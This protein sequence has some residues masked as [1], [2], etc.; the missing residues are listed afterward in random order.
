MA[1]LQALFNKRVP[2]PAFNQ[3]QILIPEV[4][5]PPP[6]WHPATVPNALTFH[7]M[8]ASG[9]LP[10]IIIPGPKHRAMALSTG[11]LNTTG[12]L[13]YSVDLGVS[14]QKSDVPLPPAANIQGG[15]VCYDSVTREGEF[16]A[17]VGDQTIY[18][19]VNGT[20]WD[21]VY[22][23]EVPEDGGSEE[24][25]F[26]TALNGVQV[27]LSRM[28]DPDSYRVYS[29]VYT[30]Y[31]DP[32][33]QYRGTVMPGDDQ[34]YGQVSAF[35][36][37]DD[38]IWLI[39]TTGYYKRGTVDSS[40][41]ITWGPFEIMSTQLHTPSGDA[42]DET[43]LDFVRDIA[44]HDNY[45]MAV[46]W[47]GV[48]LTSLNKRNWTLYRHYLTGELRHFNMVLSTPEGFLV[49]AT[50]GVLYVVS[51]D[52]QIETTYASGITGDV[53]CGAVSEI[54]IDGEIDTWAV[55]GG[56]RTTSTGFGIMAA[57]TIYT[58]DALDH[59]EVV[60]EEPSQ[61]HAS[62]YR[63]QVVGD[64]LTDI[65]RFFK[66]FFQTGRRLL[67]VIRNGIDGS[68]YY[69]NQLLVVGYVFGMDSQGL[70]LLYG[71]IQVMAF[72]GVRQLGGNS[73][74]QKFAINNKHTEPDE[75]E[76]VVYDPLIWYPGYPL[77]VVVYLERDNYGYPE[78][79]LLILTQ[80]GEA[81]VPFPIDYPIFE[82][83][84]TGL[85]N[86]DGKI[87]RIYP[88][89]QYEE[90]DLFTDLPVVEGCIPANPFYVRWINQHGGYDYY[91]F[92]ERKNFEQT[93]SN[94]KVVQLSEYI[95]ETHSCETV[96]AK[97]ER[98]IITGK[99]GISKDE[100]DKLSFLTR[101][102]LIEWYKTEDPDSTESGNTP[103]W[104]TITIDNVSTEWDDRS[105]LGNIEFEFVLPRTL[106]QY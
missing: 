57:N 49:G 1:K 2:Q 64:Y 55:I 6:E 97:H 34:G 95:S 51:Y 25:L 61:F 86:N 96:S 17:V 45:Y 15:C 60:I 70:P 41:V 85:A 69:N 13:W 10:S 50:S 83:D 77:S 48:I 30:P 62:I 59:I 42:E 33:W 94:I 90:I 38:E 75:R 16:I 81:T 93:L 23:A 68:I 79:N 56:A 27:A 52:G 67:G 92:D 101:S 73:T 22:S 8:A 28:W 63:G 31:E 82:L 89:D 9:Y 98:V 71:I 80:A 65:S 19:T 106:L 32:D 74:I 58:N 44:K 26:V 105:G 99:G 91:M 84:I 66:K 21:A 100:F 11:P 39:T 102:P 36:A 40:G 18:A 7:S 5:T 35:K 87:L 78:Y 37:I 54:E 12:G 88:S 24:F 4:S 53:L 29:S 43:P 20:A 104:H 76:N 72:N 3:M 103:A 47:E 14:Y 46:G